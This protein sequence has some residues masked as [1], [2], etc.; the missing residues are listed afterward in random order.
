MDERQREEVQ[1]DE[2]QT[3]DNTL[4][5]EVQMDDTQ[6][7]DTMTTANVRRMVRQSNQLI[8]RQVQ[9]GEILT[10]EMYR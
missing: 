8:C 5:G 6:T 3:G 9:T 4:T 1:V 7:G 10:A 2:T